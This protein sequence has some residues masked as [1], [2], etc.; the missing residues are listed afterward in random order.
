MAVKVMHKIP[1]SV[2]QPRDADESVR[3]Q[4]EIRHDSAGDGG[5]QQLPQTKP[6]AQV[7]TARSSY[8]DGIVVAPGRLL[9]ERHDENEKQRADCRTDVVGEVKRRWSLHAGSLGLA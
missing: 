6:A 7:H 3:S 9:E 1:G 2:H 4:A 8:E 5:V